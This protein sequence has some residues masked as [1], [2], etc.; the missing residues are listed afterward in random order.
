M[1]NHSALFSPILFDMCSDKNISVY[2]FLFQ[3]GQV[4]FDR[5]LAPLL[6]E[7]WLG[8]V[9]TVYH[10]SFEDE[11]DTPGWKWNKNGLFSTKSVY[12]FLTKEESSNE[13]KHIW[14]AKMPYK[15]KIFMWLVE[16]NAILTKD[17]LIRRH[18]I[19]DPNCYFCM[20]HETIEHLSF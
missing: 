2:Q 13:Y 11:N 18:W 4:N 12:E 8:I 19:G 15:I 6:F 14:K 16:R 20:D 3:H 9:D 5:W 10:Y 1:T 7:Q 17:N